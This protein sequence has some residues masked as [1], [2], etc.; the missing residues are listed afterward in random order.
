MDLMGANAP[1]VII[2]DDFVIIF[3][4][5]VIKFDD[6]FILTINTCPR[7]GVK[8]KIPLLINCN[9]AHWL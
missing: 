3:D 8:W 1:D 2:S 4:D 6:K 7:S 5:S 9:L